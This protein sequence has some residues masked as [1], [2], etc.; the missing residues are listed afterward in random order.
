MYT[1]QMMNF[2]RFRHY[3]PEHS[4][5]W[6]VHLEEQD[7]LCLVIIRNEDTMEGMQQS[8]ISPA[9]MYA[10]EAKVNW[11]VEFCSNSDSVAP[12]YN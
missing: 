8:L 6:A 3:L 1:F 12:E 2:L 7:V 10:M 11:G 9:D 5:C 4:I